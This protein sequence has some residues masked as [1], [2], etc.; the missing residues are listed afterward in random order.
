M[1]N[2]LFNHP[3]FYKKLLVLASIMP[4]GIIGNVLF[5]LI[6]GYF[7]ILKGKNIDLEKTSKKLLS[8]LFFSAMVLIIIAAI[9]HGVER[10]ILIYTPDFA[11]ITNMSWFIGYYFLIIVIAAFGLNNYLGKFN[12]KEYRVFLAVSFALSQFTFSGVL[13]DGLAGG[14]RILLN[15]IF[16]YALGGYIHLY[17]PLKRIRSYVFP[18]ILFISF[19]LIWISNHNITER[20]IQ[21]YYRDNS[22]S[23]FIQQI[24][25]YENYSIIVLVMGVVI[26]EVFRRISIPNN[27]IIN[28]L[29][30][31][32]LMIYLIHDNDFFY[33]L[34]NAQ[35]WITLLYY[36]PYLFIWKLLL[37]GIEVFLIGVII[38]FIYEK[39]GEFMNKYKWLFIKE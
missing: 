27:R 15:G 31:G 1:N 11:I 32:T 17:D 34:W 9:Y 3:L 36:H 22:T 7:M 10:N 12:Q 39:S 21:Y 29:G 19:L 6:A 13:A 20:N 26:F 16:L 2:G 28:F 5:I 35:D 14:L 24:A 33:S 38:Y 18:G 30:G 25:T 37:W 8:Q 23:D 4:L